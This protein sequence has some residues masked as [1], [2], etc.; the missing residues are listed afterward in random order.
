MN[1]PL[2]IIRFDA[3]GRVYQPGDTLSGEYHID[4]ARLAEIRA[5]EVSVLW[6]TEG[7][8]DED[9]AV[10]CFRRMSLEDD[11]NFDPRDPERF[12]TVLPNSPLS[13]D[14][15]IVKIRWCVRVRVFLARGREVVGEKAFQL[16]SVPAMKA[17]TP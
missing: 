13:Y 10:H 14:G 7:K 5:V 1:D 15:L 8:G 3:N 6:Y 17:P 2:V 11:L 9:M 16:G 12:S 4:V